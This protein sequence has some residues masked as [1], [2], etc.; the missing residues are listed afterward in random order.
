MTNTEM[1]RST[2]HDS[3]WKIALDGYFKEFLELLFPTIP[4]EI[5]W[6]KGYTSLDKELQQVT[7]DS[8]SGRRYADK[9]VKVFTPDGDEAW[10]LIHVEVQRC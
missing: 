7:P 2:D 5:D 8:I 10:V 4:P 9:L 1:D 6:D 3:P